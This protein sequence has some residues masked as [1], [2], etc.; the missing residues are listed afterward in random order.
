MITFLFVI[1]GAYLIGSI[2]AGYLLC[3]FI[4]KIDIRKYGSG[5]IGATNV[6]RVAGGKLAS[7]VLVF[8]ILKG[9]LPVLVA[10]IFS[11]PIVYIIS[12]GIAS[13]AGHNFSIFL[14]GRG[15][16]GVST[17]FGV[18]IGIFPFPALLSLIVWLAVVIPTRY[19]SLGAITASLFLPFLVYLFHKDIFLTITGIIISVI[20]IYAH[21]S[22]I[23]R[24]LT[25]KENKINLPWEKR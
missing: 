9:L 10:K 3:R 5:N 12:T 11:L 24:L 1:I 22:N 19:V 17:G 20:I 18:V 6:Y 8:D 15:G 21:R 25:K 23:K 14:K 4:K 13:I 16:K 2:P 7:A